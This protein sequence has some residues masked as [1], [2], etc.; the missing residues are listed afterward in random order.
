MFNV[1]IS[2]LSLDTQININRLQGPAQE[3]CIKNQQTRG[4]IHL[5]VALHMHCYK[6]ISFYPFL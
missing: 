2:V 3:K 4:G 5:I 1:R 6:A